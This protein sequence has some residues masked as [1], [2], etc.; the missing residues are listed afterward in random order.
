MGKKREPGKLHQDV[1]EIAFRT[2]QAA[3]GETEKPIPP[4][5][6]TEAEKD[7]TAVERGQKGGQK[8]G[9]AR[10]EKLSSERRAEIAKKAAK[11]RWS[12]G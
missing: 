10:A 1:N 7:P 4:S 6:R 2:V 8:G 11:S 3:I 9:K 12:E 5:E